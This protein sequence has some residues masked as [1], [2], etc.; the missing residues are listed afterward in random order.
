MHVRADNTHTARLS[1]PRTHAQLRRVEAEM[2][3]AAATGP[4]RPPSA[5]IYMYVPVPP[6][7][8][9]LLSLCPVGPA[10]PAVVAT[11]WISND[12][13]AVVRSVSV[14]CPARVRP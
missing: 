10:G 1:G 12:G 7:R 11:R 3:S 5:L 14:S 4:P 13:R 2:V 9:R 6:Q 8:R